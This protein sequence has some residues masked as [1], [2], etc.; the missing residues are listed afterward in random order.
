MV[1]EEVIIKGKWR[2]RRWK[3]RN[4]HKKRNV[5]VSVGNEKLRRKEC[6]SEMKQGRGGVKS[7]EMRALNKEWTRERMNSRIEREVVKRR[8]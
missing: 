4:D 2:M 8:A 3:K 7:K 1:E 6:K 5:R